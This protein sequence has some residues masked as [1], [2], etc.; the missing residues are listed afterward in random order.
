MTVEV[1]NFCD[2][3]A[4]KVMTR[5]SERVA[6]LEDV[7]G[8]LDVL[9]DALDRLGVSLDSDWPDDLVVV[10][11]GDLVHRGPSSAGVVALVDQLI[12]LSGGRWIQLIGNHEATYLPGGRWHVP[13]DE[14]LPD[15]TIATIRRWHE[16]GTAQLAVAVE[17][18]LVTHAGLTRSRWDVLGQ[19]ATSAEAADAINAELRSDPEAAFRA[20]WMLAGVSS[21][22]ADPGVIWAHTT[23]ELY[24]GWQ[25]AASVPFGQV[26]GHL[27]A[28]G[29]TATAGI[30]S[31]RPSSAE[32]RRSIASRAT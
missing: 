5:R 17:D 18:V 21:L 28:S 31:P 25:H 27:S 4:W 23:C 10:Q 13:N 16:R 24:P 30:T 14:H 32:R 3:V 2:G 12:S 22:D 9:V 1:A 6:M 29:G 20:G 8:R 7:Q 15:E 26:H 19:P 11:V